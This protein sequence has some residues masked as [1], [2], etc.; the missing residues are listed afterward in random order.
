VTSSS[1]G[2]RFAA[3]SPGGG[4]FAQFTEDSDS[5]DGREALRVGE[6]AEALEG[7]GHDSVSIKLGPVTTLPQ[8]TVPPTVVVGDVG[9]S[10]EI[11]PPPILGHSAKPAGVFV[12]VKTTRL[13]HRSSS[14]CDGSGILPQPASFSGKGSG[15]S[16]SGTRAVASDF[17]SGAGGT[18]LA[19]SVLTGAAILDQRVS[20]LD[21]V[22]EVATALFCHGSDFPG[23]VASVVGGIDPLLQLGASVFDGA[24]DFDEDSW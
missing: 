10:V 18:G 8:L 6:M 19:L 5:G 13:L 1:A 14:V 11:K 22:G 17:F 16:Q 4:I 2:Q 20:V 24:V 7:E 12:G 9:L 21:F 15:L 23:V 3:G